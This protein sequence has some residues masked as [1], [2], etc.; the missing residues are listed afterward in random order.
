MF[1]TLYKLK[2]LKT[3]NAE[4]RI[5]RLKS[6]WSRWLVSPWS[7]SQNTG[8]FYEQINSFIYISLFIVI[9]DVFDTL[10]KVALLIKW[11]VKHQQNLILKK[12]SLS[13]KRLSIMYTKNLLRFSLHIYIFIIML[14]TLLIFLKILCGEWFKNN[15]GP[16][17][18]QSV[19]M[20][21]WSGKHKQIKHID[22]P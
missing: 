2:F 12:S 18:G 19:M 6:L 17:V 21:R 3:N 20:C 7:V 8:L 22:P 4:C 16:L 15:L 14:Y 9:F 1:Y 5:H 10:Y 11:P 13:E